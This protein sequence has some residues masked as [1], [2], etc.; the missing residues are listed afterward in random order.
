MSL[1]YQSSRWIYDNPTTIGIVTTINE[2]SSLA[3]P[4][5]PQRF[6]GNQFVGAEAVVHFDDSNLTRTHTCLSVD[7]IGSAFAHIIARQTNEA[8]VV[9]RAAGVGGQRNRNNLNSLVL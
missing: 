4:T 3:L 5:Q 9:V 6:V 1:R 7:L 8:V 2:L